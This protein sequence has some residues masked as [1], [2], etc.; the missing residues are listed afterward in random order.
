MQISGT[1]KGMTIPAV[2]RYLACQIMRNFFFILQRVSADESQKLYS[3]KQ[4]HF[5]ISHSEDSSSAAVYSRESGAHA[6][7]PEL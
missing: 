5:L 1:G 4:H 7:R 2:R 3:L 6:D